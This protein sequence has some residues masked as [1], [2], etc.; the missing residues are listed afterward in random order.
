MQRYVLFLLSGIFTAAPVLAQLPAFEVASV[1]LLPGRD[2]LTSFSPF[3]TGRFTM[4]NTPLE[5]LIQVAYSV[6]SSQISAGTWL[7]SERYDVVAKAEDGVKLTP[8]ELSPRLRQLLEQRFKLAVHREPKEV[9]G[10]ALVAAKGGPKLHQSS[11]NEAAGGI[12][13]PGGIRG[14]NWSMASFAATLSSAV[15]RPVIDQTGIEGNYEIEIEYARDG[16]TNS[17]LPSV[18]TAL[19]EQL[20]LKLE[21]RRVP[22]EIVVIDHA[23]KVPI[24][25]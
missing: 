13:Y 25:N 12:I 10:Y 18:F 21:P 23:E 5:L 19:Q 17:S 24:E 11:G 16:D 20:G 2:G 8:E 15:G 9:Q 1:K 3:G 14:P 7:G 6:P 22:I 4:T